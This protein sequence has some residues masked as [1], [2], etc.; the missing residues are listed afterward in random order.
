MEKHKRIKLQVIEQIMA[1]SESILYHNLNFVNRVTQNLEKICKVEKLTDQEC[2]HVKTAI[3]LYAFVFNDL[4]VTK[5]SKIDMQSAFNQKANQVGP[6]LLEK[7]GYNKEEIESVLYILTH[8]Y[9]DTVS[10]NKLSVSFNDAILMDFI[11]K[12]GKAHMELHYKELL[13]EGHFN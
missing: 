2:T 12:N 5:A 4:H 10:S 8:F 11:G 7:A 13:I 3:L 1:D 6:S 9:T